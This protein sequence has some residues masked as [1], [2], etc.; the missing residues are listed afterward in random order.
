MAVK[1]HLQK[2]KGF[3]ESEK[4]VKGMGSE[5]GYLRS[6]FH[7][8]TTTSLRRPGTVAKLLAPVVRGKVLDVGI[9]GGPLVKRLPNAEI[10]G[11]DISRP[12]LMKAKGRGARPVLAAGDRI[13][14]RP[15]SFDSAMCLDIIGHLREPREVVREIRRVL[16]T[17]GRLVISAI[18]KDREMEEL[19]GPPG[20]ENYRSFTQKQVE[21]ILRREGLS[22][23]GVERVNLRF[24]PQSYKVMFFYA[25]KRK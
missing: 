23:D 21:K 22:V 20:P 8:L 4:L 25:T 2:M 13:P 17:G 6:L 14:F 7:R 10:H 11:I 16:K 1:T 24:I 5:P 9:G 19:A 18:E 3:Y 15:A 12:L